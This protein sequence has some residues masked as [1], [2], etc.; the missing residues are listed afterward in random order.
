MQFLSKT[1][2]QKIRY[3][4]EANVDFYTVNELNIKKNLTFKKQYYSITKLNSANM[5]EDLLN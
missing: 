3:E 1:D 5:D 4:D 2:G